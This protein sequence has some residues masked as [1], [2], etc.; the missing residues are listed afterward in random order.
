M[1]I[2]VEQIHKPIRKLHKFV[3]K[4]PRN[5]SP[6]KI[7][8]LRTNARKLESTFAALSLES[9]KNER[10]LVKEVR[11]IR[12]RAGKVRDLD[13]LTGDLASIHVDGESECQVEL[14]EHLGAERQK[15]AGKLRKLISG[16]RAK[17]KRRLRK[18][19]STVNKALK[20]KEPQPGSLAAAE[21]LRLSS[22]LATPRRFSKNNLHSYRLKVKQLR[23]VL[24]LS[25]D[26]PKFADDLGKVKD[27]IGEWH[28]WEELVAIAGNI[29]D[30][31]ANCKLTR[32]IKETANSQF[33][34]AAQMADKLR[35]KY[36][37]NAMGNGKKR[38]GGGLSVAAIAASAALSEDPGEAA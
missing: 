21:S 35:N 26:H 24:E 34:H 8:Q 9:N 23:Y 10:R 32:R 11:K 12:K 33:A 15:Q 20:N 36:V 19:S 18:A 7:H 1:A 4:L 37:K 29:L 13:V 31:G 28:D 14:L 6:E 22:E 2:D 17:M 38:H 16:Q 5:P 3:T 25:P 27:A 30:H